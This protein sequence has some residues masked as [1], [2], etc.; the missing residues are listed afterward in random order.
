M[1][2]TVVLVEDE[3][4]ICREIAQS[5]PWERLGLCLIGTAS[6]GIEGERL[7]KET[8]PDIVISD[9]RLPGQD[10]LVMLNRCCVSHAIII[11]GHSDFPY[12]RKA[13]KLGVF[14]YLLKPV[15]DEEFEASLRSLVEKISEEEAEVER[16]RRNRHHDDSIELPGKV[17]NHL[18]DAAIDIIQERFNE[19]IGLQETAQALCVSE[20]HL[21]RLFK[22]L[23]GINFLQYLNASRINRAIELLRDP[24]LNIA[25]VSSAC[26]FPTAGY[27]TKTFRRF[28]GMTPSQ[29]RDSQQT[30]IGENIP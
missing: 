7:I 27:F 22:E 19:P 30:S 1:A 29:Y 14:D 3:Q 13:I 9:I 26:G 15:D 25:M 23:V 8:D 17:G 20:G 11:S 21:S 10:G 24:R 5:T 16:L 4:L 6:D 12:M 18:V 2:Y 28:V